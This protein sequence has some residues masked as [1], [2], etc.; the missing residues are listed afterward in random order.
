MMLNTLLELVWSASIFIAAVSF[1]FALL[2]LRKRGKRERESK[3][4]R[5]RRRRRRRKRPLR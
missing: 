5:R 3:R 2:P 1:P 4:D